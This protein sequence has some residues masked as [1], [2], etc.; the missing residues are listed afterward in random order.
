[1]KHTSRSIRQQGPL[2]QTQSLGY[3]KGKDEDPV[4][5]SVR[6]QG[7]PVCF[8]SYI[9]RRVLRKRSAPKQVEKSAWVRRRNY[10]KQ[11]PVLQ[12]ENIC[13][14]GSPAHQRQW[15]G[16]VFDLLQD[17]INRQPEAGEQHCYCSHFHNLCDVPPQ[18]LQE[19]LLCVG[20]SSRY[21]PPDTSTARR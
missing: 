4:K 18:A 21:T 16:Q 12:C 15:P 19:R 8:G 17:A 1:M 9:K 6:L 13:L 14:L 20:G 3:R 7:R 5:F 2:S 10:K 11:H